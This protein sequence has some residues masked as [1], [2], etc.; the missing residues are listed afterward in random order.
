MLCKAKIYFK[1]FIRNRSMCTQ[2]LQFV[3]VGWSEKLWHAE[4]GICALGFFFQQ[5][6][7]PTKWIWK[8]RDSKIPQGH[9][10]IFAHAV[11]EVYIRYQ[12]LR[13][14]ISELS[15]S[16]SVILHKLV[17]QALSFFVSLRMWAAPWCI[18]PLIQW[19][20]TF[21]EAAMSM[22][23]AKGQEL[24]KGRKKEEKER[25]DN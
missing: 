8:R 11:Q 15:G 24:Q 18:L 17:P 9:K 2:G 21:T 20:E 12:P 6:P 19:R 22:L 16:L 13:N 4:K 14:C 3:Y 1:L 23:V 10:A 5:K 25:K 7:H